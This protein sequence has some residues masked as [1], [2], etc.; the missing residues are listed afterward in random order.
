MLF[1]RAVTQHVQLVLQQIDEITQPIHFNANYVQYLVVITAQAP[2]TPQ[3]ATHAVTAYSSTHPLANV[4][5]VF[6]AA[7]NADQA[8]VKIVI[9]VWMASIGGLMPTTIAAR[10]P[11]AMLTARLVSVLE[12]Q[13][14]QISCQVDTG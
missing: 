11:R 7:N 12:T 6:T 13:T 8:I 2:Q 3:H 10:V 1:F 5:H 14:V 9:R 4:K